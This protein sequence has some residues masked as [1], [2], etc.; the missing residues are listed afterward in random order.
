MQCIQLG[1]FALALVMGALAV[2]R[3]DEGRGESTGS[4]IAGT[5]W[6]S[7]QGAVAGTVPI[8]AV[9]AFTADGRIIGVEA[10]GPETASLGTWE[11]R[12]KRA[13]AGSF[14]WFLT[15]QAGSG[16]DGGPYLYV[17][18][19]DFTGKLDA[20]RDT[21]ELPFGVSIF[22]RDQNPLVDAP[23][24]SVDGVMIATRLRVQAP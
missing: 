12:G 4:A 19:C 8:P 20:E 6:V 7:I 11:A 24:F 10:Q 5:Y 17:A 22:S 16:I 13:M 9:L 2:V 23:R 14:L 1:L 18:R 3:A 21:A 15:L